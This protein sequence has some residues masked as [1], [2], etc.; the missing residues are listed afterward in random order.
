ML[1]VAVVNFVVQ[2]ETNHRLKRLLL[3]HGDMFLR[4]ESLLHGTWLFVTDNLRRCDD[5]LML[6]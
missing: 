6:L 2:E 3:I 1:G 4:G 5:Y